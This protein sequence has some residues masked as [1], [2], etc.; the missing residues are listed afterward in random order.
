[1][2]VVNANEYPFNVLTKYSQQMEAEGN[3]TVINDL[4]Y[5]L[6]QLPEQER[7]ALVDAIGQMIQASAIRNGINGE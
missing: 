2:L 6:S 4:T 5:I 3:S 7:K 1:M